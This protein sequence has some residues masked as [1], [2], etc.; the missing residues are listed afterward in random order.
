VDD[1]V[2]TEVSQLVAGLFTALSVGDLTWMEQHLLIDDHALHIGVG[3]AHWRTARELFDG[4]QEQFALE[5]MQWRATD[6]VYLHRGDAVC[7]VDRPVI[8]FDDGSEL[9]CRLTLL[10][11]RETGWKLAHSHLSVGS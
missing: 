10:F 6:P 9:P 2:L 1:P 4:L 3:N 5:R 11:L 7:V 8:G